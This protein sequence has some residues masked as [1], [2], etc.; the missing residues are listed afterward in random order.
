MQLFDDQDQIIKFICDV[1]LQPELNAHLKF[2]QQLENYFN[3]DHPL[4]A[5]RLDWLGQLVGLGAIG[6]H[7]LGVGINPKWRNADKIRLIKNAWE[8]WQQKGTE[9]GIRKAIVLWLL[10]KQQS[11]KL[12]ISQPTDKNSALWTYYTPYNYNWGKSFRDI[13]YFSSGDYPQE[14]RPE[15]IKLQSTTDYW[16]YGVTW[17][18]GTIE[19][20]PAPIINTQG[21][22]LGARHA[23]MEFECNESD[24]GTIFPDYHTLA[25]EI[26]PVLA[27]QYPLIYFDLSNNTKL[28]LPRKPVDPGDGSVVIDFDVDGYHYGWKYPYPAIFNPDPYIEETT[29]VTTFGF[30]PGFAYEQRWGSLGDAFTSTETTTETIQG[31]G[32]GVQWNSD[33]YSAEIIETEVIVTTEDFTTAEFSSGYGVSYGFLWNTLG[34]IITQSTVTTTTNLGSRYWNGVDYDFTSTST[35]TTI[36][37]PTPAIFWFTQYQTI[38]EVIR[39]EIDPPSYTSCSLYG[40]TIDT[41][42]GTEEIEVITPAIAPNIRAELI[43][44]TVE[45]VV[46][47][48]AIQGT[49]GWQWGYRYQSL[50]TY[51]SDILAPIEGDLFAEGIF[52]EGVFSSDQIIIETLIDTSDLVLVN[53]QCYGQDAVT[54]TVITPEHI[55]LLPANGT[56]TN[57]LRWTPSLMYPFLGSP[58]I[59]TVVDQP[60]YDTVQLCNVPGRW[61]TKKII[62]YQEIIIPPDQLSIPLEELYPLLGKALDGNQ[63]RVLI[64]TDNG[65]IVQKP[66]VIRLLNSQND[67]I[68]YPFGNAGETVNLDFAMINEDCL[69]NSITVLLESTVIASVNFEKP[70]DWSHQTALVVKLEVALQYQLMGSN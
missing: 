33:R 56:S 50:F 17:N 48:P 2:T 16:H 49:I 14:H 24:W 41:E 63:W 23:W 52:A 66:T 42:V 28:D 60:I 11:T 19:A 26:F 13:K 55:E 39:T 15:W 59:I 47:S 64:E 30:Y 20:S 6:G 46:I 25:L 27:R 51:F 5:P 57:W 44:Q 22:R 12:T 67:P 35:T 9:P 36:I 18:K 3:P 29:V 61:T 65:I 68:L 62:R 69:V 10:W 4:A 53:Y 54:E 37:P 43:G 58:E 1:G 40:I 32:G 38:T 21:S 34:E 31:Y 8:Y 45:T 70:K 7:Y